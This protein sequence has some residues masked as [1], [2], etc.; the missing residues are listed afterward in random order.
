MEAPK[1]SCSMEVVE[2]TYLGE[3]VS[4]VLGPEVLGGAGCSWGS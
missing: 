4:V 3:E 1:G 2:E